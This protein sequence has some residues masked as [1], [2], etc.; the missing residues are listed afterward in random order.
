MGELTAVIIAKLP[1]R[2]VIAGPE[3]PFWFKFAPFVA[4]SLLG[5]N[6]SVLEPKPLIVFSISP[7][8]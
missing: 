6:L 3:F 1:P 5:L 8:L 4:S 7:L 2:S